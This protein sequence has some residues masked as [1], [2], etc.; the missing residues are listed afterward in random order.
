MTCGAHPLS[1]QERV[2]FHASALRL[3]SRSDKT[4]DRDRKTVIVLSDASGIVTQGNGRFFQNSNLR[5]HKVF[6]HK[7]I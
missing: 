7:L 5:E 3:L 4:I 6:S 1:L 2:G